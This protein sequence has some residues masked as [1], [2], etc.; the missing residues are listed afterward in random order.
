MANS[1][2]VFTITSILLASIFFNLIFSALGRPLTKNK[3]PKNNVKEMA[4]EVEGNIL[5]NDSTAKTLDS[6]NPRYGEEEVEK[7]IDDFRPTDPG[8]S[9]GAG[10]SSPN[11]MN[12]ADVAPMP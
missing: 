10:H 9:P 1:K 12:P 5:E 3:E 8:H 7:L 2:L 11:P 4:T 6:Q